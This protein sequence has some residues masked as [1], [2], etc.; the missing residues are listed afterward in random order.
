MCVL[1]NKERTW[2]KGVRAGMLGKDIWTSWVRD[3]EKAEE[4]Y[5]MRSFVTFTNQQILLR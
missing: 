4:N 2:G 1:N 3:D 5:V